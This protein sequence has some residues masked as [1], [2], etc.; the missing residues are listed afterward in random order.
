MNHADQGGSASTVRGVYHTCMRC[1]RHTCASSTGFTS[2]RSWIASSLQAARHGVRP[3]R[4]WLVC[5]WR[6][7]ERAGA[8]QPSAQSDA[9][10]PAHLPAKWS[11]KA[12]RKSHNGLLIRRPL[13]GDDDP[14]AI[15]R[16]SD[17]RTSPAR[18]ARRSVRCPGQEPLQCRMFSWP[19]LITLPAITHFRQCLLQSSGAIANPCK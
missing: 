15:R 10:T 11:P 14:C 6:M 18:Q 16:A 3:L 19:W 4:R 9:S 1:T 7:Q 2:R 8:V 12:A 13:A 17:L 5:V